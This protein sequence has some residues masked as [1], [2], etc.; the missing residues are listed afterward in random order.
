MWIKRQLA[1]TIKRDAA[2]FPVL[3]LTGPRQVGK[4]SLA[5]RTFP[6]HAY[7]TLDLGANAEMAET[8]PEE[9]L[10]R[11]P[12]PCI[13]DKIQYAPG[14]FRHLKAR[15]DKRRRE[16]GM[17]VLTGS[18]SF[19]LMQQVSD[20][21][22][23][24]AA[25]VSLLGLSAAEWSAAK[26]EPGASFREFVWR[27]SFPGLWSGEPAPTRDRW[28]QS[29]V[30]T[31]LE[32]DVRNVLNVGSLRDFERFLRACAARTAQTLNMSELG[33][34]VGISTQTA[35]TWTSVLVAS[36]QIALLEPYHRSLGRRLV[37]SPKLYFT[38]TGL[39]AFLAGHD[40]T[41]ALWSSPQAGA[42]FENH[43]VAQ[44]I[45]WRDW[46]QPSAGL[47][48][49]RDQSGN[50]VDLLIERRGRLTGIE[51]KLAERPSSRDAGGLRRLVAFYGEKAI[52]GLFVACSSDAPYVL[53][54]G[55]TAM[56]GWTVFA[57]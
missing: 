8:R 45:R 39:A 28:Y 2:S 33:R 30:A 38:D 26:I 6:N 35:R 25:V 12:P 10:N 44:W 51:C 54:D 23:G 37:K 31:Y 50:E 32:R 46:Q 56:P 40:S 18:Q 4:T 43:V 36:G 21:L 24:R 42:L 5:E 41:E 14:L 1:E 48:Y 11:Y 7:V 27:G 53:D 47:W 16:A 34:D 9:F 13:Y 29:Y 57:V 17:F 49:W 20:S 15:V 52:A 55:V 19:P 22:A 3:V